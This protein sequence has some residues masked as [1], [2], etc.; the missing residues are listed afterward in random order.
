M[1]GYGSPPWEFAGRA[2]YQ[3]SLMKMEDARRYVPP[4]IPLVNFFVWTLGDFY[5]AQYSKSPVG[6]FDELGG[7]AW[8][9]PTSCAW[10]ARVYVNNKEA[11]DHGI[12]AVGLPSRLAR[13]K[14][15]RAPTL[16]TASQPASSTTSWW[17]GV[18]KNA[19]KTG[20]GLENTITTAIELENVEKN[21]KR[22]LKFPVCRVDMPSASSPYGTAGPRIQLFL[23]SFSG[24]TPDFPSLCQYSLRLMTKVRFI[25]PLRV[26]FPSSGARSSNNDF[27][28]Q[29]WAEGP[30]CAWLLMICV[31][32][33]MLQDHGYRNRVEKAHQTFLRR[34]H[35]CNMIKSLFLFFIQKNT[36]EHCTVFPTKKMV[37]N[38][39]S[40]LIYVNDAFK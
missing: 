32:K 7:L 10:A 1:G 34:W 3:L 5:L 31:W 24:A 14:V 23:P 33:L 2:L 19:H 20:E 16:T 9:F 6:A 8:N 18:S 35:Q 17:H 30:F 38:N 29:C 26:N 27:L 15:I 28:I 36:Q 12:T 11:R 37:F 21:K 25:A 40:L 13:F 39:T 22:G 4:E